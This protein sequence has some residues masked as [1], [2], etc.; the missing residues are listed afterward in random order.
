MMTSP[1]GICKKT[2]KRHLGS[3]IDLGC[4]FYSPLREDSRIGIEPSCQY[5][6]LPPDLVEKVVACRGLLAHL[7][8]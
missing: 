3:E 7:A 4:Q 1:A 5:F 2:I 6:H 8:E